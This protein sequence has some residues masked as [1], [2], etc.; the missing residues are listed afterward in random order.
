VSLRSIVRIAALCAALALSAAAPAAAQSSSDHPFEFGPDE[1]A[2]DATSV[3]VCFANEARD[4]FDTVYVRRAP[5]TKPPPSDAPPDATFTGGKESYCYNATGLVTE[6]PY[7]IRITG[8]DAT[9]DSAPALITVAARESGAF[10]LDGP[11]REK[12]PWDIGDERLQLAVTAKDRRW[13]AIFPMAQ[14]TPEGSFL[15]MF[16]SRRAKRGWTKP[17]FLTTSLAATIASSART[18]AVSW[19]DE[20]ARYRPRYRFRGPH[21]SHFAARRTVPG[22]A[23]R[24]TLGASALDRR[25]HLHAL[26]YGG[27]TDGGAEYRSN[28]SGKWREQVIPAAWACTTAPFYD[29]CLRAP[30]LAYDVVTDRVVVVA[31]GGESNLRVATKR[32][33]AKKLGALRP[34]TVANRRHLK[35][36][37]LTSR[38]DRITLG[39]AANEDVFQQREVGPFYVWAS[40]QL[41]RLPG[42]TANDSN[43]RV[44]ARSR[45]RVE[46][47]WQR[48]SPTW[49]R[50]QQG[51][52]TAE[53]VRSKKT[54]RWSIRNIHHRTDSHYDL[55][56]SLAVTAAGRP[57]IAYTRIRG[58]VGG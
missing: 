4:R 55:L 5:G 3:R 48:G 46:L 24:D 8:H 17:E 58:P 40:G 9:G 53:S 23:R 47:A 20:L 22:A 30:L 32:A 31:Q 56:R 16:Y 52:W 12:F 39:L 11:S 35:A 28:A 38:A 50:S 37:S 33:S 29:R 15:S 43:L 44:A 26:T 54:G 13:H 2:V 34:L 42:T 49:D 18:V 25:G 10:V 21:A 7:T 19:S 57:L 6:E 41:V 1:Y 51:I 45:D 36:T 27:R 14:K